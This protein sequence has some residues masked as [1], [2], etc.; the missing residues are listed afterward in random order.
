[1]CRKRRL[2]ADASGL[3]FKNAFARSR[4]GGKAL[5]LPCGNGTRLR[6]LAPG[7]RPEYRTVLPEIHFPMGRHRCCPDSR[8]PRFRRRECRS[9]PAVRSK[10]PFPRSRGRF[11]QAIQSGHPTPK[12]VC[13]ECGIL[14]GFLST[15]R[16]AFLLTAK[17]WLDFCLHRSRCSRA[18][19]K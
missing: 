11:G 13:P 3:V 6:W 4:T 5:P 19:E 17:V 9:D 15:V 18:E 16:A 12:T 1:M 14:W 10:T 7:K 2:C 8:E